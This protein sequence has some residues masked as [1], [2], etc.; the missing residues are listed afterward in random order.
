MKADVISKIAL[1]S[2]TDFPAFIVIIS[3]GGLSNSTLKSSHLC[4]IS[5]SAT[6]SNF[7]KSIGFSLHL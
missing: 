2:N 1:H 6:F 4:D 3:L 7:R 5:E